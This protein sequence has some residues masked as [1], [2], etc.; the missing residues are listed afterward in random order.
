MI[1]SCAPSCPMTRT[2]LARIFSLTLSFFSMVF[3]LPPPS[4]RGRTFGCKTVG[5]GPEITVGV[6]LH[7][8]VADR[9]EVRGTQV[10]LL[11]AAHRDGVG[12]R[13][14]VAGHQHEG[15]LFDLRLADL[16]ADLF[17]AVVDRTTESR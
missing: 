7:K 6:H 13:L 15:D 14:A 11:A 10:A 4:T 8:P 5:S 12:D 1:P 16:G 17:V 2:T 3:Y 9:A